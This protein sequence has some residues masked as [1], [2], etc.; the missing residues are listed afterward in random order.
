MQEPEADAP[1]SANWNVME[2]ML[3]LIINI[4]PDLCR[5]S[6]EIRLHELITVCIQ[7]YMRECVM[8]K[9]ARSDQGFSTPGA[10]QHAQQQNLGG[11]H[12]HMQ[13]AGMVGGLGGIAGAGGLPESSFH[14]LCNVKKLVKS[15][16][17]LCPEAYLAL[18]PETQTAWRLIES[19]SSVRAIDA[20]ALKSVLRKAG[21]NAIAGAPNMQVLMPWSQ[22]SAH[23]S[24]TS[25]ARLAQECEFEK[26]MYEYVDALDKCCRH[27]GGC[28]VQK[29]KEMLEVDRER[30][31]ERLRQQ[32]SAVWQKVFQE[33]C[34]ARSLV[35]IMCTWCVSHCREH[36]GESIYMVSA[37][38]KGLSDVLLQVFV[39]EP[40]SSDLNRTGS[41]PG[42][43][44][45]TSSI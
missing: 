33:H 27:A 24:A 43:H 39:V 2:L 3:P 29:L 20:D 31:R 4:L 6:D 8:L 10:T 17:L 32:S 18:A 26:L 9:P 1:F 12:A 42:T 37:V 41:A 40:D 7:R 22:D 16:L 19:E 13:Q 38:L 36:M 44:F 30:D 15:L 34:R 25:V 14:V 23:N 5:V 21:T 45:H 28:D 35:H 11:A